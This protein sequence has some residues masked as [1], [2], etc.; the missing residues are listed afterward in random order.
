[1]SDVSFSGLTFTNT[2]PA[3]SVT[4][5]VLAAG[6]P[7]PP[8]LAPEATNAPGAFGLRLHGVAGQQY[9]LEASS[10]FARWSA[11]HTNAFTSNSA[12]VVF[13]ATNGHHFFRAHSVP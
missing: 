12:C 2:V 5:H 3:Q 10:D 11:L 9:V 7:T 6:T 4:L 8:L 13:L 1:L